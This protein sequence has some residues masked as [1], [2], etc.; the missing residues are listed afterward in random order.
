MRKHGVAVFEQA[1]VRTRRR[2]I[3]YDV[4]EREPLALWASR[5]PPLHPM[6]MHAKN[7]G[8]GSKGNL[9]APTLKC[10]RC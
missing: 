6:W 3:Q 7:M 8:K 1:L 4:G 10:A 9:V 5:C 2:R